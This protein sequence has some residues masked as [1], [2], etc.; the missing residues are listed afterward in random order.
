MP[1][2]KINGVGLNRFTINADAFSE[3][4]ELNELNNVLDINLFVNSSDIVPVYP[5]EFAVVPNV[6]TLLKAST[7][8]PCLL[9]TS[10]SPRDAHESR[11]PSS[12]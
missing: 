1:V 2:D 3:V 4:D 8:N 6:N 10:P 7:A 12:A 11:M 9:Y 5:Y